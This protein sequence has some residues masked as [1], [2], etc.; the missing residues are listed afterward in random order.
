MW[1]DIRKELVAERDFKKVETLKFYIRKASD[2]QRDRMDQA[3][4]K[5]NRSMYS[6]IQKRNQCREL[7]K[8]LAK[9]PMVVRPNY[10]KMYFLKSET[11]ALNR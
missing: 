3:A 1:K 7:R 8:E 6:K 9:L 11:S 10:V 4:N 2:V 5:I